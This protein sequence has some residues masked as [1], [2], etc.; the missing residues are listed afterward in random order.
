MKKPYLP[1]H[2]FNRSN[3]VS[4][5]QLWT[6]GVVL[7][8]CF[9]IFLFKIFLP[10]VLIAMSTPLWNGGTK[11]EAGVGNAFS[12]FGNAQ[13]LTEQNTALNA[14]V[15]TLQNQNAVLTAR[16]QDL[17]KLLGGQTDASSNILAGVLARPPLS[18]YDTLVVA[19]GS[20][21]GV[22]V[23]APVFAQGGVPFGTVKSTT[24]DSATIILLSTPSLTTNGW[25]GDNRIPLTLIGM[26]A[27]AF[28]ATLPKTATISVGDSAYV[29]GPGAVPIGTVV[30]IDS[31]PSSPTVVIHIQPIVNIF[32][33]TWVEIG[34]SS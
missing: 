29:S 12:S 3:G 21:Q 13:A 30:R 6:F 5:G 10:N 14:E 9:F 17:T 16:T 11:L 1:K 20:Q 32:S 34:R 15:L 26:G 23:G 25:I 7:L 4:G 2:N 31:D 8:V 33:V 18:P 27:G 22:V 19:A 28:T 24:N